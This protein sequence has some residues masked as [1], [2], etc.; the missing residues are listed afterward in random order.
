MSLHRS[1]APVA[2][3][4]LGVTLL[5]TGHG[6]QNVLVPL[7]AQVEGFTDV[8]I[9]L[10]ASGYFLGFVSGC[11]IGPFAIARAGHIRAFAAMVSAASSIALLHILLI[12]PWIWV[13]LRAVTGF[14]IAGLYLVI[15][16][17]LNDRASNSDRGVILSSYIV[18]LSLSMVAGQAAVALG[19]VSGFTLFMTASVMVSLAVIPVAMTRSAQPAPITVVKLR[20]MQL[21]KASPA[22][23][24]SAFL[25]GLTNGSSG[26]LSPLYATG[27]GLDPSTAAIFS[28]SILFGGA[29][30]QWPL[31][32]LSDRMDRRIVLAGCA[33]GA[34]VMAFVL[35]SP[36]G[37]GATPVLLLG[38]A[39]GAFAQPTY[40]IGSAH[41]F[42]RVPPEL[43]VELSSAYLL[44]YGIGSIIGPSIAAFMMQSG[45]PSQL[46]IGIGAVEVVMAAY[47]VWRL[48]ARSAPKEQEEFDL[49]STAP[50]PAIASQEAYEASDDVIEPRLPFPAAGP[51]LDKAAS[52]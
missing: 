2:A 33:A 22:A 20:P 31:G 50:V 49:A 9:G 35:A 41:A 21:Y 5:F 43:Y 14:C 30:T 37:V 29:L 45:G 28:A 36:V 24:I 47:L 39:F 27:V 11:L 19:A 40:A 23:F 7:R 26:A 25:I 1:L 17:W 10:S 16:S 6:L 42:D 48:G 44:T 12:D 34:A 13:L 3:L 51:E 18:V 46:F 8:L 38:L 15:E 52:R 4:L 32:Q